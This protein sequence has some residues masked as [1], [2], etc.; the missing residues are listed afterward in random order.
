MVF[1]IGKIFVNPVYSTYLLN[2]YDNDDLAIV[3][4]LQTSCEVNNFQA[5]MKMEQV[6]IISSTSAISNWN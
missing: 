1:L 3:Y 5:S 6:R 4:K 2:P